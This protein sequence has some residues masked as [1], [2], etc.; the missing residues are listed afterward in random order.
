MRFISLILFFISPALAPVHAEEQPTDFRQARW[1]M[2]KEQ[3]KGAEKKAEF[4]DEDEELLLYK[5]T[6]AGFDVS[7]VYVFV[8]GQLVRGA[9]FTDR[10]HSNKNNYISDYHK[11]KALLAK[12]YGLPTS[13]HIWWRNDRYQDSPQDWGLAISIG[14]LQYNTIWITKSTKIELSLTGN[15]D[16][17]QNG[18]IYDNIGLELLREVSPG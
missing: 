4:V 12:K 6:L 11:L 7:I 2:S 1:G 8:S 3:V 17:I 14:H 15:N 10:T 9:Y 18:I 5:G 16:E 13:S